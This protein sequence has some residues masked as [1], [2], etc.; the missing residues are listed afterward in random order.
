MIN[1]K[2]KY[3]NRYILLLS[4]ILSGMSIRAQVTVGST[5]APA[6][7]SILQ[8]DG[9]IGGFRMPQVSESDRDNK[10]DVSSDLARGLMVFNTD[11]KQVDYWDGTSWAHVPEALIVRNGLWL[12]GNVLKLGKKLMKDTEIN[13]NGKFLNFTGSSTSTFRVNTNV[14]QVKDKDITI[15]PT[16]LTIRGDVFSIEGNAISMKPLAAGTLNLVGGSGSDKKLIVDGNNVSINS[17]I[18]YK[19]GKQATGHVLVAEESGDA[20]WAKLRPNTTVGVG[21]INS[22]T[23]QISATTGSIVETNITSQNLDLPA[24][25]WLIFANYSTTST[26][27]TDQNRNYIWTYLYK[28][29]QGSTNPTEEELVTMVGAA[30]SINAANKRSVSKLVYMVDISEP[31]SFFIKAGTKNY[32]TYTS[33]SLGDSNFHAIS[34]ILPGQ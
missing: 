32:N 24:G 21:G 25:K 18:V 6:S 12:D 22:S 20:Y 15:T 16:K 30:A 9:A 31:T 11:T 7:F 26:G 2:M 1:Y 4:M 34:I 33:S 23:L 29:P 28:K 10:I 13:M 27:T 17:R 19:D 5:N 14:F 8:L 3:M